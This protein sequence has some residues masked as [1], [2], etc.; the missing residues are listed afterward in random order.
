MYGDEKCDLFSSNCMLLMFLDRVEKI[1][2]YAIWSDRL[3][4]DNKYVLWPRGEDWD[5]R[6][7][8]VNN[9]KLEWVPVA[10]KPFA[11]ENEAWHAAYA[12][13]EH[14]LKRIESYK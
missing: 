13:W 7:K 14:K 1:T 4:P 2:H 12:D 10:D 3:G 6:F 8:Q 9:N 5:V 11:N